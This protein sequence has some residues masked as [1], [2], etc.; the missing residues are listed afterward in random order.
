MVVMLLPASAP[1]RVTQERMALPSRCT[2]QAPHSA[3]PQPYLVPVRPS[4]SRRYHS[5]GICGSPL[6]ER[7]TPL[8]LRRIMLY[9]MS[10]TMQ[11]C[12]EQPG[13]AAQKPCYNRAT[14]EKALRTCQMHTPAA[15]WERRS[16]HKI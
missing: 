16:I 7:S 9:S 13:C 8:T 4:T 2:V 11:L 10:E 12:H 5:S 1:M 15:D 6:K 3:M 14:L